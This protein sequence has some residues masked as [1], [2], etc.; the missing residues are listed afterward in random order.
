MRQRIIPF[1]CHDGCKW[2]DAIMH[3]QTSM[4]SIRNLWRGGELITSSRSTDFGP[5]LSIRRLQA[6]LGAKRN[7]KSRPL[8][9]TSIGR[10]R[11]GRWND[12]REN[13]NDGSK[14]WLEGKCQCAN[15]LACKGR[16]HE[17]RQSVKGRRASGS[18]ELEYVCV[19]FRLRTSIN[20]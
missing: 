3:A 4:K 9:W 11:S 12:V 17:D 16:M 13:I 5:E 19:Y 7:W 15:D 1:G 14:A 2:P 6:N 8:S 18:V 20:R 10:V